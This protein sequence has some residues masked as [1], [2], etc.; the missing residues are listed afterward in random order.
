MSLGE[1]LQGNHI[2]VAVTGSPDSAAPA[3]VAHAL[4]RRYAATV[5]VVQVLDISNAAL[6]TPLPSAFAAARELIGDAPYAEDVRARR[7]QFAEILGEPND[8]PVHIAVGTPASE[9]LRYAGAHH[10]ALIVM[11]IRRH[12]A[13]DRVLRDETTLSVARRARVAVL[14]VVPG[15]RGLPSTGVV[16]V[17]FGPASVR[18]ARAALDVLAPPSPTAPTTLHLVYVNARA[19]DA[20]REDT[21]GE[22][23]V[24]RLG[25][26]SAF[27]QLVRELGAPPGVTVVPTVRNG[28]VA[29]ELLAFATE[30]RADLVSIGSL[31]HER[32]ERWILGSVTTQ[33]V[34]DGR[35][36][37]LVIPPERQD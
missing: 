26:T 25:V 2:L 15:L 4:A 14:G 18:A 6:P 27:E 34:R 17:D 31:R 13:V 23:L 35:C 8:W 9:I 32:F 10:P 20:S 28:P 30:Q 21:A 37:V 16:G 7:E 1:R 29:S 3:I 11:G 22:A 36:S 19:G 12:G 33:V 24:H 5:S